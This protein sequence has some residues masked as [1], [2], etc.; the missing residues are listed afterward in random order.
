VDL[1]GEVHVSTDDGSRGR[2]GLVTD[3]V[4][5]LLDANEIGALYGCGPEPMLHALEALAHQRGMPCQLG[6]EANML[7]GMG[8]CGSCTHGDRLVCRDG[9]VFSVS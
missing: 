4:R 9:P 8:V 2:Q 6:Y 1:G 5:E 7:C 3:L